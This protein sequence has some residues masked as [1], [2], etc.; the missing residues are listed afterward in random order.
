MES[1]QAVLLATP[2]ITHAGALIS[3][4]YAKLWQPLQT[5]L[6]FS[7]R[8]TL[9]ALVVLSI[10]CGAVVF[11]PPG[12][13]EW[14]GYALWFVGASYLTL[15]LVV[16]RITLRVSTCKW[17]SL[18]SLSPWIVLYVPALALAYAGSTTGEVEA[19][20]AL[21]WTIP[22]YGGLALAPIALVL[23]LEVLLRRRRL[24]DRL[25]S[26]LLPRPLPEARARF[27][28]K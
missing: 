19:F 10:F 2:I 21:L 8:P 7:W 6:H 25:R 13:G 23:L 11:Y 24:A 17:Y 26:E 4:G 20:P 16:L 3:A 22:G 14:V 15:Q 5:A 28:S 1:G 12:S 27:R 9:I 18:L